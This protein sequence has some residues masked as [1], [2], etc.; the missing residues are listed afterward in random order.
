MVQILIM[1]R[2]ADIIFRECVKEM[3]SVQKVEKKKKKLG[4]KN[5]VGKNKIKLEK[6]IMYVFYF[7]E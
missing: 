7:L 1:H 3:K 2:K 4:I 5:K 6:K